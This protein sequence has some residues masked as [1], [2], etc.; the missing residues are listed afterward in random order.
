MR[1][2]AGRRG[3]ASKKREKEEGEEEAVV[4]R[5]VTVAMLYVPFMS[6]LVGAELC[7]G[8]SSIEGA[9]SG[10]LPVMVDPLVVSMSTH[11]RSGNAVRVIDDAGSRETN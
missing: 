3:E 2:E 11:E 4:M 9:W 7:S 8:E 1:R 5:Q 6:S 10:R